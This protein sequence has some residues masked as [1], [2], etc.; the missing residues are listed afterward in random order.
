M[1]VMQKAASK[2]VDENRSLKGRV[3]ELEEELECMALKVRALEMAQARLRK[4]D[5][6]RQCFLDIKATESVRIVEERAE[7]DGG[8][9]SAA[10]ENGEAPT[11]PS[12]T[13]KRSKK[14]RVSPADK[15]KNLPVSGTT[16]LVPEEVKADPSAY[17]KI[18]EIVTYEVLVHPASFTRH[19]LVQEKYVPIDDRDAAPIMA[20]ALIRFSAS[21]VSSSLAVFI[22]LSKYLEHGALYRLEQK[23]VRMGADIP[24]Q[25]Q[26][27]AVQRFAMWMRPLYELIE[28]KAKASAYLQID[29]TF[30]KYIN[31]NRPGAGQGYFWAIHAPGQSMVFTW[32]DNRRHENVEDLIS[33]F[34]GLLQ[35]DAY[36]AYIRYAE[37]RPGVVKLL[38]CWA[39]VFRKFRDALNAEPGHAKAMMKAIGELYDLEE[40][41]DRQEVTDSARA[42]LRNRHS[43]PLAEAIKAKLDAHSADMTIP[44]NEFRLAVTYAANNW[45]A[46]MECLNHGHTRLD[47]NLLES[48]FR[49]T[50]IGAKNWMFIGHPDAGWKSAVV[51]TLLNCCRIHRIEPQAYLL[52]VLDKLIPH[53]GSPPTDLLEALL[54]EHW[55]K[56]NPDHLVKEPQRA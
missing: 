50:K 47:T 37:K 48:K 41:W 29:E 34:N 31:G 23:F 12:S 28:R 46:L 51:Y 13:T 45:T 18:G 1:G 32:I 25:V 3:R 11:I 7:D 56:A 38:A 33:G 19:R 27:D 42:L 26:S 4:R 35:S 40:E 10:E 44:K 53:D 6:E 5:D 2:L 39:H 36:A 49:P 30:I 15:F 52:D 21:Y 17:R 54:P 14:K 24:R 22:V 43:K 20:K 16:V 9:Q 8:A 55:I